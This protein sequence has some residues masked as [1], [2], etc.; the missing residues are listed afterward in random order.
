MSMP[1]I[2]DPQSLFQRRVRPLP[3]PRSTTRSE[4][5]GDRNDRSMSFRILD[6]RSGGETRS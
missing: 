2:V 3:H 5:P 1:T 4:A 6:P